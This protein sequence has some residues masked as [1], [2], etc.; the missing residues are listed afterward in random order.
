MVRC[1][2]AF[3]AKK[4]NNPVTQNSVHTLSGP[5]HKE[6]LEVIWT[7]LEELHGHKTWEVMHQSDIKE[8]SNLIEL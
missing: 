3:K 8:T 1:P 4:G 5:H 2:G 7:E 6:F